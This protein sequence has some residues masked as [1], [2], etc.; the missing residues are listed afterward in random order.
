MVANFGTT[1][2]EFSGVAAA[3]GL[4]GVPLVRR[5]AAWWPSPSGC[6]SRAAPTAGSSASSWR[7]G[8]VLRHLRRR[9][10]PGRP[11]LGRA[12]R[13]AVVPQVAA[14]QPLAVHRDRRHRHHAHALGAVLHPGLGG[15]QEHLAAPVRVHAVRDLRGRRDHDRHRLLHRRSPA[16]PRCTRRASSSSRRRTRP[17]RSSRCSASRR[18]VPLRPRPAQ[19]LD[20][21]RGVLPLAT[22]YVVCEAFGFESRARPLVP[23]GAGLQRHHHRSS[24]SCRRPW[25]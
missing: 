8:F 9:R 5:R 4:F 22:A 24:C 25:R 20:P 1:V 23:R 2:A 10:P 14:E 18:P 3:C 12:A 15:R 7:S 16:P 11:R 21:R 6:S 13:G 17:W 19:R